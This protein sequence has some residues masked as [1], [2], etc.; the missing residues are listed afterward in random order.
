MLKL[1]AK[2]QIPIIKNGA[3]LVF[4]SLKLINNY[5]NSLLTPTITS[6]EGLSIFLIK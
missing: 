3:I 1:K 5:L 6:G 4:M 2:A